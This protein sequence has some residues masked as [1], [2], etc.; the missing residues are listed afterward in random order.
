MKRISRVNDNLFGSSPEPCP[1]TIPDDD[2]R[3]DTKSAGFGS[4]SLALKRLLI[5]VAESI[6]ERL[7]GTPS[8]ASPIRRHDDG[9][10]KGVAV[11]QC[12]LREIPLFARG[13]SRCEPGEPSRAFCSICEDAK[14][15][16]AMK[17]GTDCGH[18]YCEDCIRE[19]VRAEIKSDIH[20]IKC[21]NSDCKK[22]L[23]T[24]FCL[25]SLED[26]KE[27]LQTWVSAQK[28]T[29]ALAK[30]TRIRCPFKD[31]SR[32]F[33]DD[34]KGFLIKACPQCWRLFCR[35]CEVQWHMG[36]GCGQYM[37]SLRLEALRRRQEEEKENGEEEEVGNI[38]R[39]INSNG[40]VFIDPYASRRIRRV[41]RN[42]MPLIFCRMHSQMD[43]EEGDKA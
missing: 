37:F 26:S 29:E 10:M 31:C 33:L 17:S 15:P 7:E 38:F 41:P 28:E 27:L 36:V 22:N 35:K 21:P 39:I 2:N 13:R 11:S 20:G 30:P 16:S 1:A 5:S 14:P 42:M 25:D 40:A 9:K 43:E 32:L 4:Q 23:S 34:R 8:S 19:Y 3:A 12:S 18:R 24:N 6:C